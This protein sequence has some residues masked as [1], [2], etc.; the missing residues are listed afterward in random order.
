MTRS[1][2]EHQLAVEQLLGAGGYARAGRGGGAA[3]SL[4]LTAALGRVLAADVHA[5]VALPPFDNSQMDG[6]AVHLRDLGDGPAAAGNGEPE[7]HLRLHVGAPVP[8]GSSP[9]PLEPGTAVPIMTGAMVP[10]GTGAV[11]PIERADPPRFP[12]LS[13]G[14]GGQPVVQLPAGTPA[15]T[16]IRRAGSDIAAGDLALE[17]GTLLGPAQLGLLAA[18]GLAEVA[19]RTPFRVLLLSTGDEVTEPGGPLGDGRIY[20]ANTTLLEAA[21]RD[22]GAEVLRT[23][24]LSDDPEKLR[25]ALDTP[26]A[27]EI[28]L[29]L[30]SGGISQGAY[31]VVKQALSGSG[32]EF[33]GV[34]LQPGGPQ[35]I[36]TLGGVPF[37]GFPGNPVSA[38]VSFE[39]FL[40]PALTALTG[41]PAPR[42]ALPARLTAPA[43]SPAAKHQVRRGLYRD[44]RVELIGGPGSHLLNALA[45]SNALVHFPVGLSEAAAG[46]EVTVWLIGPVPPPAPP[47]PAPTH[48]ELPS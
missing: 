17:A 27:A 19:V 10:A 5:P 20:D 14:D 41:A 2:S 22:A 9:P 25:E 15:G 38:L 12:A 8:A 34:A 47:V 16:F 39:M 26:P 29:I 33:P 42:V 11:V 21:L 32:V 44:G 31:E 46:D 7:G 30:T 37:L 13:T 45:G 18:C 43:S 35:A 40:R 4:P 24:V 48:Q 23:R 1:V 28:H 3:E 6:Y 36:G